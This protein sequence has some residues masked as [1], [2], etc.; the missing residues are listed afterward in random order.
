MFQ[1]MVVAMMCVGNDLARNELH[2]WDGILHSIGIDSVT[3]SSSMMSCFIGT[4]SS[5]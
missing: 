1:F 2:V 5:W 4:S 3:D